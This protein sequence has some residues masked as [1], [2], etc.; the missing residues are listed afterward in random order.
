MLGRLPGQP[1][2]L[3]PPQQD[4]PCQLESE[5]LMRRILQGLL[6][7]CLCAACTSI[8]EIPAQRGDQPAVGA[9]LPQQSLAPAET[10][11]TPDE[12][13]AFLSGAFTTPTASALLALI[14][15]ENAAQL[16]L[17]EETENPG[18]LS[19]LWVGKT[20]LLAFST[21]F[22]SQ[23]GAKAAVQAGLGS[24]AP[25]LA[26]AAQKSPVLAWSE[27]QERVRAWNLA[28]N[29]ELLRLEGFGSPISGLA[30]SADGGAIAAA[31][32]DRRMGIWETRSGKLVHV[33]EPPAWLSHLAFSPDGRFLAGVDAA[34]FSV[35]I[36]RM[37]TREL[38]R[39]LA[40]N[41]SASPA[42]Y[43]VYFSPDWKQLAWVARGTVQIMD[44]ATGA[45]G[46][47][48]LHEDFV[49]SVS[50]S[51]DGRLIGTAAAGVVEGQ[52]TPAVYLWESA[53]GKILKTL[54]QK[55]AI[56]SLAFSPDGKGLAV[57]LQ[58]GSLQV[59]EA[60]AGQP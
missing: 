43:G 37:D 60:P 28:Q 2:S 26:V 31:T 35:L 34:N 10:T 4:R 9:P 3:H 27:A 40:W 51:A 48:L 15:V 49:N 8:A 33:W 1:G 29:R 25:L 18:A 59:W 11:A 54:P 50:W 5:L 53:S 20:P 39:T 19:V 32:S 13:T 16:K 58:D 21:G 41:E 55:Q 23:R 46:A 14:A 38:V 57:L 6:L 42:L 22:S 7:I 52:F 17:G 36:Y 30:V 44:F 12:P 24:A 45:L 47:A 56:S